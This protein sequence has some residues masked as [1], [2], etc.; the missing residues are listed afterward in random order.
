MRS[1]VLHK[2]Q[3]FLHTHG[4]L[5]RYGTSEHTNERMNAAAAT[6]AEVTVTSAAMAVANFER[7]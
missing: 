2:T 6:A 1:T 3:H 4:G 7:F 5:Y